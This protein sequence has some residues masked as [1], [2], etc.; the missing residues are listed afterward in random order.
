[1]WVFYTTESEG[2]RKKAV[3][4]RDAKKPERTKEYKELYKKLD[5]DEI[6]TFGFMSLDAWLK[7]LFK[8]NNGVL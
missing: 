1:M 2:S 6:Y 4:C 8:E 7:E 3:A 5:N